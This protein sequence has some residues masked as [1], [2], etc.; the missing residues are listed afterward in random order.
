MSRLLPHL[1]HPVLKIPGFGMATFRKLPKNAAPDKTRVT[2]RAA[3]LP[4]IV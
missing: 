2:A 3:R 1:R 4:T